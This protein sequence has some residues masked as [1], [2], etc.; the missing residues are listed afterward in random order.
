MH[1]LEAML[2][3]YVNSNTNRPFNY[4]S[5]DILSNCWYKL[6]D[7]CYLSLILPL[8]ILT[9]A[10]SSKIFTAI[11]QRMRQILSLIFMAEFVAYVHC[12]LLNICEI[13]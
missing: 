1:L 5:L 10:Y 11:N 12:H 3:R 9:L 4:A 2:V 13:A 7:S 6:I 8:F